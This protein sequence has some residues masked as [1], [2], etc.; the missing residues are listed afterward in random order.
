MAGSGAGQAKNCMDQMAQHASPSCRSTNSI[1]PLN[2]DGKDVANPEFPWL[3]V[4]ARNAAFDVIARCAL[5][6]ERLRR[7][8]AAM[9]SSSPERTAR[10]WGKMPNKGL[11]I[12]VERL[13]RLAQ[14]I[15][16]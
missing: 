15:A 6:D 2:G 1:G 3:A 8:S 9:A 10:L 14:V 16:A 13:E 11:P 4:R 5:G 7:L 12:P